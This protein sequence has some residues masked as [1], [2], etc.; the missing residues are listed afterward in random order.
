MNLKRRRTLGFGAVASLLTPSMMLNGCASA[1]SSGI[2]TC[3][4]VDVSYSGPSGAV[5]DGA[6]RYK[7]VQQALDAAPDQSSAPWRIALRAGRYYEMLYVRKPN[8]HLIGE[9]RSESI[10]TYDN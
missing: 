9:S 4:V 5:V 8:I 2:G 10:L 6:A 3:A 1:P 7:T